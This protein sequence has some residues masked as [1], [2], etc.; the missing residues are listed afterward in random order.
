MAVE[1]KLFSLFR[2]E[3]A[4]AKEY[5]P[6]E[7]SQYQNES[8]A[9]ELK[10]VKTARRR[11]NR[12]LRSISPLLALA[13]AHANHLESAIAMMEKSGAE[14][15]NGR[16]RYIALTGIEIGN[17]RLKKTRDRF[18]KL[19][20]RY[21]AENTRPSDDYRDEQKNAVKL[22]ALES[23]AIKMLAKAG[24]GIVPTK[25]FTELVREW[26]RISHNASYNL[27]S[28]LKHRLRGCGIRI[29][30]SPRKGY[31]LIDP[32]GK[33]YQ[34]LESAEIIPDSLLIDK[35]NAEK[36]RQETANTEAACLN[37]NLQGKPVEVIAQELNLTVNRVSALI[38]S[39]KLKRDLRE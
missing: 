30:N 7:K 4:I 23:E 13:N 29:E 35:V 3:S 36:I 8:G 27:I 38:A 20:E 6:R 24:G 16:E 31:K 5:K 1:S 21:K 25:E 10:G 34:F 2:A 26:R 33:I 28:A 11:L 39:A 17:Q 32:E 12:E 19:T 37:L 22:T 14:A 15:K 18:K 9:R